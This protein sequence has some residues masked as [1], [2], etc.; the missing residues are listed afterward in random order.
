M[1]ASQWK[2]F[3]AQYDQTLKEAQDKL[4]E[5]QKQGLKDTDLLLAF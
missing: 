2:D 4:K 1:T 3:R 5:L